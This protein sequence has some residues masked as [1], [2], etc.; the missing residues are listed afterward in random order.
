VQTL[1]GLFWDVNGTTLPNGVVLGDFVEQ[2]VMA[3]T[4]F[5]DES[6]SWKFDTARAFTSEADLDYLRDSQNLNSSVE[7]RFITK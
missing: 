1:V 2:L 3:F 6:V 5:G 4:P 7:V